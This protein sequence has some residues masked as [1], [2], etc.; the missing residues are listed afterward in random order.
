MR[1]WKVICLK[2]VTGDEQRDTAVTG[3]QPEEATFGVA[4]SF[5]SQNAAQERVHWR[6][7]LNKVTSHRA[8]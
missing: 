7:V 6:G 4:V 5:F 8:P 1:R 3:E 2:T